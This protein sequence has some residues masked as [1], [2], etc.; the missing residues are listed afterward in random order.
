MLNGILD[1]KC[2]CYR[3]IRGNLW[4]NMNNNRFAKLQYSFRKKLN[5]YYTDSGN[6]WTYLVREASIMPAMIILSGR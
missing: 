2:N 5:M 4:L 6:R 3:I 1:N